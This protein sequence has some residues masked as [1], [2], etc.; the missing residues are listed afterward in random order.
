MPNHIHLLVEVSET[1]LSRLMQT[2]QFRYTRNFNI[3]YKKSGHLFQGRYKAILCEK[4][5]YLL[6]LSA[7]IH[8]NPVLAGLTKDPLRYRWS[9]YASYMSI[10]KQEELVDKDLLLA[11]FSRKRKPVAR[12]SEKFIM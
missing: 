12:E 9:S 5:A 10:E 2:L 6:E 11:H 1:P 7:Y 8:F 3:K 4:D